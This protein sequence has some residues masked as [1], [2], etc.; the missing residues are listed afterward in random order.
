MNATELKELSIDKLITEIETQA[1]T[2]HKQDDRIVETIEVGQVV[3]QGDIYL[4][5]VAHDHPKG[6]KL[7]DHQLAQGESKGS[8]HVACVDTE[9]YQGVTAPDYI[10][11]DLLGPLIQSE[12][13]IHISH[14]EHAHFYLP[15]GT[16][17]VTHQMDARTR[18]RVKD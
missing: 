1:E 5:R 12:K 7:V 8:R 6:D 3:R 9:V 2:Q 17:Q 13:Q 11:L 10:D 14:P 16:Y 18:E 15:A 4:H